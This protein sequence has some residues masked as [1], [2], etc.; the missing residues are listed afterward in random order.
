[1][2]YTDLKIGRACVIVSET[3]NHEAKKKKNNLIENFDFLLFVSV[4]YYLQILHFNEF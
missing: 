1:M 3:Y 4:K 2:H